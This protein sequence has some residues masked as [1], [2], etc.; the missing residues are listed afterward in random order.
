MK[1]QY[2]YKNAH[3]EGKSEYIERRPN[4]DDSMKTII[5][6]LVTLYCVMPDLLPGPI[7]DIIIIMLG[8]VARRRLSNK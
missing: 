5:L 7:D 3:L 1:V 4:M 8:F 2:R 6:I